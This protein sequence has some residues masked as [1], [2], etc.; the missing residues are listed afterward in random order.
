[1]GMILHAYN[2]SIKK[3]NTTTL[4]SDLIANEYKQPSVQNA[5]IC[6]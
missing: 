6:S 3:T 5:H 4:Y 1:M 2:T